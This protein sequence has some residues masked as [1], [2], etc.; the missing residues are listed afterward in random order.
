MWHVDVDMLR[1]VLKH[2]ATDVGEER[3]VAGEIK[4]DKAQKMRLLLKHATANVHRSLII[5]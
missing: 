2:P 3:I 1:T 5:S 4:G